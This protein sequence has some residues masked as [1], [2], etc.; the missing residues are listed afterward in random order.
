MSK[1]YLYAAVILVL[2]V[3]IPVVVYLWVYKAP[4][5]PPKPMTLR[6]GHLVADELH[7][8]GWCVAE[9]MGYIADE[10]FEAIHSEYMNGPN[11]M[12]HFAAGELDVAYVGAAPFLTASAGGIDII[13]VASSNTEG[14]SI[15]AAEEIT[16]VKDLNGTTVGS[17]GIGTI[18]DY[19]L[20]RVEEEY[21]I[22][23]THFYAKVTDLIMYFQKGE[24]VGYI[25]W[26]PHPTRAVVE[27]IRGAHVLIISHEI[28]AGHQCCVLAVRGDWVREAPHIVRRIVRWHMK[29]QKWVLEHPN[30]TEEIIAN[31]SGL[32][33]DLVKEAHPIVEHPYPPY[34][35]LPSCKIMVEGLIATGKIKEETVPSIDE[36]IGKSINNSFVEELD[37]ELRPPTLV[38]LSWALPS[39]LEVEVPPSLCMAKSSLFLSREHEGCE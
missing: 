22:Q 21:G 19:M 17:P 27:K 38:S 8:P 16:E 9:E 14:S 10:G 32:S 29:A 7:Q 25:A 5:Q 12:E 11:E 39:P 36:F 30:E 33:I 15:V 1:L 37:Q 3:A 6:I 2:T 28:L 20:T 13:A 35:D 4:T 31:Y 34:V 23:I 24:I 26:E 18:Q